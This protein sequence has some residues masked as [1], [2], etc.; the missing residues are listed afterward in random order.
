[1]QR[2]IHLQSGTLHGSDDLAAVERG[3]TVHL[4]GAAMKVRVIVSADI[5]NFD[6][7]LVERLQYRNRA[8]EASASTSLDTSEG[9]RS[10]N[11]FPN[12]RNVKQ[13]QK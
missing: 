12:C 11:K 8:I 13:A 7:A 10:T 6:M 5:S 4:V 2:I 9:R 1:M 3:Q